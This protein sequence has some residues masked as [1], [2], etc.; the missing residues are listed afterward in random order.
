[1][2]VLR[3]ATTTLQYIWYFGSRLLFPGSFDEQTFL[4]IKPLIEAEMSTLSVEKRI[5]TKVLVKLSVYTILLSMLILY[6][7][8]F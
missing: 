1:M 3:M 8:V 5:Q 4:I 2:T 6:P 7:V